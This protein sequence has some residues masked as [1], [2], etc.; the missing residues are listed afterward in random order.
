MAKQ[1]PLGISGKFALVDDEDYEIFH[2]HYWSIDSKGYAFR[3][4]Y[5][6][7]QK[8]EKIFLHRAIMKTPK[9][10]E[11]D[12][13]NRIVL[14][15]RKSNLRICTKSQNMMNK[16]KIENK[17]SKYKGVSWAKDRNRWRVWIMVDEKNKLLGQFLNEEDAAMAY[18]N[19]AIKHFGE[20]A[21][22]NQIS[23]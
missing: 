20:F 1:I 22:I 17:T 2:S 19:A 15:N 13:I 6:R 16:T 18:N 23:Q 5:Q 4:T 21:L 8:R 9:G 11:T 12:H 7:G 14:D 3:K 10:M